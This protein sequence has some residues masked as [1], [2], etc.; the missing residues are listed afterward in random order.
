[1]P[2]LLGLSASQAMSA[3]QLLGLVPIQGAP[4]G[5]DVAGYVGNV[6]AQDTA[7]GR[8][9]AAGTVVAPGYTVKYRIGV[10]AGSLA[11]TTT[12]TTLPFS[13]TTTTLPGAPT[14][15]PPGPPPA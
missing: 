15:I 12:T 7:G 14:T 13:T 10:A 3:L 1:V 8:P 6:A 5:T 4:I 11:T 9:L 2:D